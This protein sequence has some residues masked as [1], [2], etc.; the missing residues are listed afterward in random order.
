MKNKLFLGIV[1]FLLASSTMFAG[2][3]V[4]FGAGWY[5]VP[6]IAYARPVHE[7]YHR[8]WIRPYVGAYLAPLP[9]A[10]PYVAPAPYI[11]TYVGPPP[12]FGAVWI[13]GRWMYGP[14]G[15]YW[16]RGYWGHR[17]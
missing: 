12:F 14:H 3:G 4:G 17:R 5:G 8:G 11:D 2:W 6:G 15:R 16:V 1:G 9:Y 13:P 7:Y 10:V